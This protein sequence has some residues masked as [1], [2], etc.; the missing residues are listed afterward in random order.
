MRRPVITVARTPSGWRAELLCRHGILGC[1]RYQSMAACTAEAVIADVRRAA[2]CAC[3]AA[4][5]VQD[6]RG[7][8]DALSVGGCEPAG[9]APSPAGVG[10]EG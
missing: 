9:H 6:D 8:R 4:A 1:A 2:D 7:P 5:P 3:G 10:A